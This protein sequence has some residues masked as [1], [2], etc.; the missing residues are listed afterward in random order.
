VVGGNRT[1]LASAYMMWLPAI[2]DALSSAEE[3]A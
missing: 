1:H 2:D 3:K